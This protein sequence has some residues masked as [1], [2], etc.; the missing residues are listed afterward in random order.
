M[1]HAARI[2]VKGD[3][4]LELT[5]EDFRS[6][7]IARGVTN[8][9]VIV[10]YTNLRA[11]G[12]DQLAAFSVTF[13][14]F[15]ITGSETAIK[16]CEAFESTNFYHSLLDEVEEFLGAERIRDELKAR[17]IEISGSARDHAMSTRPAF[18]NF[19]PDMLRGWERDFAAFAEFSRKRQSETFD[20]ITREAQREA[21][22]AD[23]SREHAHEKLTRLG[24]HPAS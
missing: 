23:A 20:R 10:L 24:F 1:S 6:K 11:T 21:G 16:I 22:Q 9:P 12:Y 19:A 8:D 4:R 15:L 2:F 7:M 18:Q 5:P 17:M 14:D 3:Q 13:A